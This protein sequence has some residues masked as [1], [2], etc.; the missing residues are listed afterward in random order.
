MILITKEQA[1]YLRDIM[2]DIKITKTC[3]NKSNGKRAKR[4]VE[5]SR[6]VLVAL[7]NFPNVKGRE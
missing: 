5:E 3:R 4:Y 6:K 1:I 7:K 2:P